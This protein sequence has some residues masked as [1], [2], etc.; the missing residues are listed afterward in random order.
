M[1]QYSKTEN[2]NRLKLLYKEKVE[3]KLGGICDMTMFEL[4]EQ[5]KPDIIHDFGKIQN[6]HVFDNNISSAEGLDVKFKT[7]HC[8]KQIKFKNKIPYGFYFDSDSRKQKV[9]FDVLH[10]NAGN[11][12][13]MGKFSFVSFNLK[14]IFAVKNFSLRRFLRTIIPDFVVKIIKGR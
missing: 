1:E 3:K 2:I 8:L 11:K 6:G 14:L 4:L 7:S 12:V 13:Y 9:F 5:D 10:F